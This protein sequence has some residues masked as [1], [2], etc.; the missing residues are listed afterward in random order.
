MAKDLPSMAQPSGSVKRK[1]TETMPNELQLEM[2]RN[3]EKQM[4][5]F[6][7]RADQSEVSLKPEEYARATYEF[8]VGML[9]Q[10]M[11][12]CEGTKDLKERMK[13]LEKENANLKKELIND[14]VNQSQLSVIV[15]NLEPETTGRESP[16]QLKQT[17]EKVLLDMECNSECTVADIF[18]LKSNSATTAAKST[19]PP[20]KITFLTKFE[21]ST[22]MQNLKKLDKYKAISVSP[23]VPKILQ[24]LYKS[25]DK[26]LYE[27]RKKEKNLKGHL[28]IRGQKVIIMT[29][30]EGQDRFYEYN[31][32]TNDPDLE[33]YN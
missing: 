3:L 25:Q 9:P 31:Q 23:H 4:W 21:K 19:F 13:V 12:A 29:K 22:F 18:R 6:K 20:A 1:K 30:T 32:T 24:P 2:N 11:D 27:L 17:F 33:I 16:F 10:I 5:D 8:L 28:Q 15:K 14:Q 26:I 7:K